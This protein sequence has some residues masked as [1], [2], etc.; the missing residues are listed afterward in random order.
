M[1]L[2]HRVTWS[3]L[4]PSRL[5]DEVHSGLTRVGNE[6]LLWFT[7]LTPDDAPDRPTVGHL[8]RLNQQ[9]FRDL[10]LSYGQ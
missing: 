7:L 4:W 1:P 6:T 9:M 2:S 5:R 3:S 10:R 8:R